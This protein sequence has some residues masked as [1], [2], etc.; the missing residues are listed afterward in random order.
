MLTS[1][2]CRT[3]TNQPKIAIIGGGPAG[4]TTSL[5]FA[6]QKIK[7]T[8][9]EKAVFP[10]EKVCGDG[11]TMEVYRTLNEIDPALAIEFSEQDFVEP[12]GGTFLGDNKGREVAFDYRMEGGVAP[13]FIAKRIHFDNWLFQKTKISE[14]AT[15]KE[16]VGITNIVRKDKG[17]ILTT[18]EGEELFFDFIVGCDGERSV[19]KKHLCPGGIKKVREHH[20]GSVRAY[21][22]NVKPVRSFK[23]LE[24][25]PLETFKG[26]FW[27]F[28]LP[29]GECNVGIGGLSSEIS[30]SKI[31][32][33]KEFLE[34]VQRNP[35]LKKRF[36]NAEMIGDIQ[37]W[38]IP[39]NSNRIDYCGDGFL[40]IGDSA[41]MAEPSTGKGIGIAMY[42]A[43]MAIPTIEKAIAQNDFS[44]EI[45]K[46]FKEDVMEKF[47]KEWDGLHELT[48]K[49]GK[50]WVIRLVFWLGNIKYFNKLHAIPTR[51]S[52]QRFVVAKGW[53][54]K[55]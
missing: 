49:Y 34:F 47:E 28:H 31:N 17:F 3:M 10:R 18:S 50:P 53:K 22:K 4:A 7:H 13:I 5:L 45:L 6:K 46:E 35:Y 15:I 52:I 43:F 39:L 16:G 55:K 27:I 38:G 36:E 23:P 30:K 21:Y 26:Y 54:T 12:S 51:D 33:K 40:I 1:Y 37:G 9:F 42:C 29:N 20:A 32:L 24:F 48:E 41:S 8:L 11:L 14:F 25:Y 44:K 19:V 2:I